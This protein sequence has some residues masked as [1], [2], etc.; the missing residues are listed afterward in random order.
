VA[1]FES[2]LLLVPSLFQCL[3]QWLFVIPKLSS[4]QQMEAPKVFNIPVKTILYVGISIIIVLKFLTIFTGGNFLS[5]LVGAAF[6]GF[7]LLVVHMEMAVPL[8]IYGILFTIV[9]GIVMFFLVV[10][11]FV[12]PVLFLFA[13]FDFIVVFPIL[14]CL[15]TYWKYLKSANKNATENV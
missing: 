6:H 12:L 4:A 9:E 10:S 14:Y 5:M 13:L 8:L 2:N 3:K 7:G 11:A 15:F 1:V